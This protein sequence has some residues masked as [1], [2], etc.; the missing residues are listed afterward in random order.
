MIH[1]MSDILKMYPYLI[2][3]STIMEDKTSMAQ[4]ISDQL[5]ELESAENAREHFDKIA[6]LDERLDVL[7]DDLFAMTLELD[8]LS[9]SVCDPSKGVFWENIK[10]Y[11][12]KIGKF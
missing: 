10:F 2:L 11:L 3:L 7:L 12:E 9:I 6:S 5:E 4:S 8:E 1:Y